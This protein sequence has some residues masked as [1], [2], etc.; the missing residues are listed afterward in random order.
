MEKSIQIENLSKLYWG[1]KVLDNVSFTAGRGD[2]VGIIGENGAGKSTLIKIIAGLEKSDTGR[3]VCE[4][5][6]TLKDREIYFEKVCVAFDQINFYSHLTGEKNLELFT[7]DKAQIDAVIKEV[8]LEDSRHK[9]VAEYSLGMRQRLGL[10]RAYLLWSDVLVMDEPFNGLDVGSVIA[11]KKHIKEKCSNGA[12]A[13]ISSHA[14]KELENFCNKFIFMHEGKIVATIESEIASNS[15]FKG[16]ISYSD[17]AARKRIADGNIPHISV[18]EIARVYVD[19][20]KQLPKEI[21]VNSLKGDNNF[22]EDIYSQIQ[23]LE[24]VPKHIRWQNGLPQEVRRQFIKVISFKRVLC[25]SLLIALFCLLNAHGAFNAQYGEDWQEAM[26]EEIDYLESA[27][28]SSSDTAEI[29][30]ARKERLEELN[31]QLESGNAPEYSASQ[32]VADSM[33]AYFLLCVASVVIVAWVFCVESESRARDIYISRGTSLKNMMFAKYIVAA[34][35]L[36]ACYVL[37]FA[38]LYLTGLVLFGIGASGEMDHVRNMANAM[39]VTALICG[40]LS[41]LCALASVA[42]EKCVPSVVLTLLVWSVGG[43]LADM[44]PITEGAKPLIFNCALS[45]IE[46]ASPENMS[47]SDPNNLKMLVSI[48]SYSVA[49]A[50]AAIFIFNGRYRCGGN[51]SR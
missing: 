1:R 6:I 25:I 14:L 15:T 11:L 10:A 35:L 32:F 17:E 30:E 40:T 33:Q 34:A 2:V 13:I 23:G 18:P 3:V 38:I 45:F 37:V 39:A 42:T 8:G 16:W 12:T 26:E 20:T 36:A 28:E 24:S 43:T 44:M 7:E 4:K 49:F 41:S 21:C 48:I 50:V 47:W 31:T 22:L 29:K 27:E 51:G 9:N 5:A 19:T 46:G